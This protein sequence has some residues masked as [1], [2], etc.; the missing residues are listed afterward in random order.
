MV[1]N[2]ACPLRTIQEQFHWQD[3]RAALKGQKEN[4]YHRVQ[5]VEEMKSECHQ[6]VIG[7]L[8][9]PRVRMLV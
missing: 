4:V 6:V 3:C 2:R 7:A 5:E 8:V 1:E 9:Y